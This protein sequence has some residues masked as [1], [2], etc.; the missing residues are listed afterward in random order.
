MVQPQKGVCAESNLHALY[1]FLNVID[2]DPQ[3]I[4]T[5]IARALDLFQHYDVEHY[6][7][8]V[9]GL[10]AVG[11]SYWYELYPGPVPK[12]LAAFPDMQCD[13]RCAPAMQTDLFIQIRADRI[14]VCHALGI[15]LMN[16]LRM[17]VE[18]VEAVTG[19]RYLDGRDLNGFVYAADNPRGIKRRE[20]AIVEDDDAC[21]NG[22]S[23]V[24]TQRYQHDML[25]WQVLSERQQEQIIGVSKEHNLESQEMSAGSH[26]QRVKSSY[27]QGSSQ[28]F[29]LQGMPYG[30]M[31]HQGLMS[32]VCAANPQG[33]KDLLYSQI[34][35]S[36]D[37][38]YDRWLDFSHAQTGGAYFAPAED[39]I[40]DKTRA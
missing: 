23:Y 37:G 13:D 27:P 21:L 1:L 25:R 24:F 11:W 15:D 19:F 2:D 3:T 30:D 4:R 7:A 34:V 17:H 36:S 31:Q 10:V 20:I 14:D 8:M 5:K 6:E 39:F 29:L 33:F 18:L 32:V 12:A 35:G 38:D 40:R 22:G 9:T 16:L 28:P 26:I